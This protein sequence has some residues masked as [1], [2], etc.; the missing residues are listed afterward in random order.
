MITTLVTSQN[1][2]EKK[3]I[4]YLLPHGIFT[5]LRNGLHNK[6]GENMGCWCKVFSDGQIKTD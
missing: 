1:W 3:N 4:G 2:P 6:N 5:M